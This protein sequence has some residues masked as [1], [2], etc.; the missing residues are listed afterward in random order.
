MKNALSGIEE[1]K[2][3]VDTLIV[4]P[5]QKLIEISDNDTTLNQAFKMADTVLMQG[6]TGISDLI[7]HPGI[8]NVDFA[9]ICTIMA[10]KGLAHLGVGQA[11]GK[12]KAQTAAEL[13]IKSPLLETSIDGAK[14]IIINIT[15]GPDLG[16]MET[17]N[18]GEFIRSLLDPGAEII[19]GTSLNESI[20]DEVTVTVVA[21]GLTLEDSLDEKLSKRGHRSHDLSPKTTEHIH[22]SSETEQENEPEIKEV[23]KHKEMPPLTE[24]NIG[25]DIPSFLKRNR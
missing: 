17:N 5:N 22:E 18:A 10:D 13:A 7:Y 2:K 20:T 24:R 25:L 1:L 6:V 12:N 3:C 23:T 11:K 14:Y 21:T 15:G 9:D 4:I 8:I 19:F 16:L